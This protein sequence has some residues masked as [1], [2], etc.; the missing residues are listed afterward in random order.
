MLKNTSCLLTYFT[1]QMHCLFKNT[2]KSLFAIIN[3]FEAEDKFINFE[4]TAGG[5]KSHYL[6]HA[7][8]SDG[9]FS[10]TS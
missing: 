4:L 8:H 5:G 1:V 7:K 3:E 9:S 2:I 6:S 10:G